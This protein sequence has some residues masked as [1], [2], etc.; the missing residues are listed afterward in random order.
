[1]PGEQPLRVPP[2]TMTGDMQPCRAASGT[3]GPAQPPSEV[4]APADRTTKATGSGAQATHPTETQVRQAGKVG[5]KAPLPGAQSLSTPRKGSSPQAPAGK[6][7]VQARV[8][9][10]GQAD[11]SPQ[12]LCSLSITSSRPKTALA[13]KTPE[14]PQR[15]TPRPPEAGTGALLRQGHPRAEASPAPEELN[16]RKCFQETP[17]SFTSTNYTSPSATPGPPPLRAPQSS[18]A[19]PCRAAPYVE[20]QASGAD[21][22][23]PLAENSFPGA[24]FGVPQAESEPFPKGGSPR[25]VSFQHPFPEL[26]GAG[27]KPFP[28]DAAGPKYSERALVFAF[29]QPRGAW[30]EEPVGTGPAYPLPAQ[31]APPPL[32]CYPGRPG[33]LDPHSDLSS[34][35]PPPGAAHL[36]P[37]PFSENAATFRDTLHESMTNVL[38]ERPPSAHDGLGS[39]REPPNSLPQRHFP[40]QV[41]GSPGASG[42][43]SSPRPLDTDLAVSGPPAAM[44]PPLWDPASATYSTPPLGPPATARSVFFEAQPSPGRRLSL[45]QSP[46]L[47]WP[48]VLPATGPSPHRMEL[49]N[50]LPFPPGTPEWQGGS[51]GALGA[52]GK[53]PGPGEK[54]VVL[55]TSPGQQGSSSPGLFTCNGLKDPGAQPLLFAVAQPQVSP[56]GTPG[57][58]PPRVVG[59]SP[60]ESPLP[61]PATHTASSSTCSSL[62]P[63]SSS[64]ANTSSEES[65][66][67]GPLTPSAFFHPPP[68]PQET[69]S[70]FP[71]PEPSH[72]LPIHYQPEPVK[73]FP[74]PTEGLGAEGAFKCL[75]ETP[76]PSSVLEV[77]SRG[78]ESFPQEPPPYSAHHFPLS[79]ASLDQ[80]DVL[81]TC[82][83][84]DRNYSSLAAFLGHRQFCGLLLARAKDGH[85]QPPALPMPPA[86]PSAQA[87]PKA[88]ASRNPSPLSHTR[89]APFLLGGDIRPD[90]KDDPLRT[91]FLPS[92]ATAPFPLP[93]ADLDLEDEA[94]LD[95]L[96]TE[97]LNG[98]GYQ[99]D[100][101]EIDSSFIDVFTDEEP[102]GPRGSTTGE[103]PKTRV[104]AMPESQ[105]KPSLQ[106]VDTPLEPQHLHPEDEDYPAGRPKTRSLGPAPTE[107]DGV[108]LVSQQRR[109]KRFKLFQKE[110]DKADTSRRPG[111]GT[112]AAR[113]RPRRTGDRAEPPPPHPRDLRT[114]APKSHADPGGRALLVETRSP[115]RLRLS[116][117]GKEAW[118]RRARGGT[119]SK[120]LIHR[121]VQQKNRAREPQA[122]QGPA[123]PSSPRGTA[124]AFPQECDS[125][126]EEED[127][128]RLR[129]PRVRG[130]LRPSGQRWHRGEKRKEGD[131]T[132]GPREDGQQRKPRKVV[133]QGA[134]RDRVSLDPEEPD[135]P[136]PGLSHSPEDGVDPE[137]RGPQRLLQVLTGAETPE[138]NPPP[139]GFPQDA[140]KPDISEELPPDTTELLRE[141]SAD[142][143]E[144]GSPC[145]PTPVHPQP[146]GEGPPASPQGE[147]PVHV[148][149]AANTAHP[150]TTALVLK[151][152]GLRCG[153][154]LPHGGPTGAP[155]ARKEP[156][157]HSSPP[158]ELLLGLKVLTGCFHEAPCPQPSAPDSLPA[159]R[160]RLHQDGVDTSSGEPAPPRNP[161]YTVVTGLGK[162]ELPLALEPTPLFS[163]LPVGSF[164]PPVY[165]SLSGNGD[166]HVP[167]ACATPPLRKPQLDPPYPSFLPEK[168]WSLLEEE[169]PMPPGHLGPF[170]GL[171]GEKAFSQK[172]PS[173]G[174]VA[175]SLPALSGKVAKCS[176]AFTGG[177]SEEELEIKR[178]VTELESQLLSKGAQEAP[179]E[180]SRVQTAGSV[181]RGTASPAPVLQ[182][183]SPCRDALSAAN[184]TGP[185]ELSP[186][187]EGEETAVAAAGGTLGSPEEEWP[188]FHPEAALPPSTH[189][190]GASL[191]FHP[192]RKARVSKT[193]LLRAEGDIGAPLEVCLL[194][195]GE[196]LTPPSDVG[197]L[198]KCSP[199]REPSPPKSNRTTRTQHSQ[200]PP[201]LLPCTQGGGPSPGSCKAHVPCPGPPEL[202]AFGSPVAH[203]TPSLAIRGA[204]VLPLGAT[205]PS[206]ASH[207]S[208]PK[209]HSVTSTGG[210]EGAR[211]LRPVAGGPGPERN[212]HFV[213]AGAST[214]PAC[215]PDPS[216]SRKPPAPATSPLHQLQLLVARAAEREDGTQSLQAPPAANTQSPQHGGPSDLGG[217]S[218]SRGKMACSPAQSFPGAVQ[219]TA[220]PATA[221]CQLGPEGDGYLGSQG[222][223]KKP[224]NQ[225]EASSLQPGDQGRPR[226]PDDL[227]TASANA[228]TTP[229]W[230]V[231]AADQLRGQRQGSREAVGLWNKTRATPSST[232]SEAD[233]SGLA[234]AAAHTRNGPED[235]TPEEAAG[236]GLKEHLPFA[237]ES[238]APPIRALASCSSLPTSAATLGPCSLQPLP[239]E[240]PPAAPSGELR[241][242]PPES[243]SCGDPTSP[244]LLPAHSPAWAPPQRADCTPDPTEAG[245]PLA[246]PPS[247]R[248]S[249]CGPKESQTCHPLLGD[250]SPLEDPPKGQP[251]SVHVLSPTHEG[252]HPGGR[253]SGAPESSRKERARQ[254]PACAT[255]PRPARTICTVATIKASALP[256]TPTTG[257]LGADRGPRAEWPDPHCRGASA[258]T[259][260]KGPS[261][262]PPGNREGQG[263]TAVPADPSTLGTAGPDLHTCWEDEAEASCQGQEGLETPGA[264]HPGIAKASRAGASGLTVTCP[265]PEFFP[266]RAT[267][268]SSTASNSRPNSPQNV[269]NLLRQRPQGDPL[270]P[271]DPRQTP[272]R[273]R[274]KP[275]F[276]ENGHWR[277]R[278]PS[279]RPVT[280]EVCLA[281]FRSGPGLS[282]HR[283]RKHG[284]HRDAASQPS[285]QATPAPKPGK[286]TAQTCHPPG[287]KSRRAPGKEKTRHSLEGPSLAAGPPPVRGTEDALG[288][289]MSERLR[290]GLSVL[291]GPGCPPGWEPHPPGLVK[292]GVDVRPAEP[293]KRD[294]LE[295]NEPRP[296]WAEK[297][298]GQRRG[299]PPADFPSKSE[300]KVNK[301]VRKPRARRFREESGP[302]V[303]PDGVSDR[304]NWNPSPTTASCPA[305]PSHHL[306]PEAERETQATQPPPL[307][308]DPEET[309][310]KKPPGDRVV[311]EAP[312]GEEPGGRKAALARGCRGPRETRTSGVCKEPPGA[313][314]GKPAGDGRVAE[315][316]SGRGAWDGREPPCGPPG[317]PGACGSEAGGGSRPQVPRHGPGDGVQEQQSA[318]PGAPSPDLGD[319]L[320]L[321]DD[322]ASFSQ[323]FPPGDRL[324]RKKNPRVYGKRCKK[325]TSPLRPEPSG[326]AGDS[327]ALSPAR[328]PT[329]LSDSGSPC[330]SHEDP[331]GGVAAG[332]PE[333]FLLEGFLS[334]KVPGIDPWAPS[335]SLLALEPDLEAD[336]RHTEDHPS[337]NIP[338][339]HMVPPAWRGLELQAPADNATS[340]LG[341][342]SPEPPDLEQEL[343]DCGV[344]GSA[345]GL[346]T[347]GAK[348]EVQALC[349][350]EG[351]SSVSCL[352]FTAMAGSQGPRSRT[353]EAARARKAP[354]RG[355]LAKAR[356]ASYKCRV[357]FQS[358]RGLGELD[359]HRLAHSPSP[360]PTCYMCVERRFGSR[361]LLREHL[362]EKH[363]QSKVGPWACGMCLRE[364]ADV[365]MYNE[366]LREHAVRFARKGQTRRTL[367]DLPGG[368]EGDGAVMHFLSGVVG[369]ASKPHRG[370][371]S[372]GKAGRGPADTLGQDSGAGKEFPRER[373][374]PKARSNSSDPDPDPDPDGASAQGSPSACA[375]PAPPGGSSPEAR[376]SG[377]PLLPAAPVHQDCKDPARDCHHCGK[378]FPKPFKLQRHLAV[379]SPQR[380]YLC[381][382]CP[383]VYPEHRE[384]RAHLGGEHGLRGELELQH[385]PLYACELCANVT[386]ISRRSF[387]CSSCNYTF[388]KKEQFDRHMDKHRRRGQQPFTFRGVRRPRALG[389]KAPAHEGSLP[390]K[391]RRVAPPSSPPRSSVDR[392][393]SRSS[394]PTLS[395]GSLP[396]LLQP[397]R[398]AAPS[399]MEGQPRTPERPIDPVGHPVRGSDLS[400]DLQELLPPSLSPFP[401]AS[402]DGKDGHKL[403]QALES[404]GD[405]ASPGSPEPLLQEAA[406]SEGSLPQPG[407]RG[408]DVGE[409]RAAGPF[410]GKRRTPSAPGKCAPNHRPE[411]SSLLWKEKQVSTCHVAPSGAT[412]GPSHKGSATKPGGCRS[413]SKDRSASS[414]PSKAPRFPAQPKK[415][416]ASPTHGE[417]ARGTEDRP[418]PTTLKAKPGPSSQGAGGPQQG[419]KTAGGSQPQPASGQLQSETATTPAKPSCPGQGPAPDKPTPRAPT[420][421]YPKG[422]REAGE[423]GPRGSL[424]PREGR[425]SSEKKRKGRAPGPTRG[426]GVGSLGRGPSVPDR[427]YRAPRKQATPSR[428]LPAKPRPCS[429]NST[430]P[431]QPSELRKGEP[432]HTHGDTRRV[433][434]GLGKAV[435]QGRPLHR[436][437]R[438]GGAVHGTEP[439]HP[440]ACRTAESQSHLLS[441]LFGQRLTSFKI[442]LKKDPPE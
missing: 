113:L 130:Q 42:V 138:E 116:P 262:E 365:W 190:N 289:E 67:P 281:S 177:L 437:P 10:A 3:G 117:G 104:G 220:D 369:Q 264:T 267:S 223:A 35:L 390:S 314:R 282:R 315:S 131:L 388:A 401:A 44:L 391:R 39:P 421:G 134:A 65:Q 167:P 46:P 230:L 58:P 97:A 94:K 434:E 127:G 158:G 23:P 229:A 258:H 186:H 47:P 169:S 119:W 296:K 328:L 408:Q 195:P 92:L 106:A 253:M 183:A 402:P 251:S 394:S 393:L 410:S 101:P 355:R 241:G 425:D 416:A 43:G 334:S 308:T 379:H 110:L 389:Q 225:V 205:P 271:Q 191:S 238:P 15:E 382:Q 103:P 199:N 420:K 244:Q 431:P 126:S 143:C 77:G 243:P 400:S 354:G 164:D 118:R 288:S 312:P 362:Q 335:P 120:E 95:S 155:A 99:S 29:H 360:P 306:S 50:Q 66:L 96:I 216:P 364:V 52:A 442:P 16:F 71:S 114:Q 109:G 304:S 294:Q 254:F 139:L 411:A 141:A 204:G 323:L 124:G 161:P 405:E 436:P 419:T 25:V 227:A 272:H 333:S 325:P 28:E 200:A 38:P 426:E 396:A 60:S 358:F 316:G 228:E 157:P 100:N 237:G 172:C 142:T 4:G 266:G 297:G 11:S 407:A 178:L 12:Q 356:R 375:T 330:L 203:L 278:A 219:L 111:Q 342:V 429:Q 269:R 86:V 292:P 317:A 132:P 61:S 274:K 348:L 326:Q 32:P 298:R 340:P 231:G 357:C 232:S 398:E 208:A 13:E 9:R 370:K 163:G 147:P 74:F 252:D 257:G 87:A 108:C 129:G 56:R 180:Q 105:A 309:S 115:K 374:R 366:H 291:G 373:P 418:K 162:A 102:S 212:E 363:V 20:F 173:E 36:A 413:S 170:P 344:P 385:T 7:L 246:V 73:A 422:P 279:G 261:S 441:Q 18:G 392:P 197:S 349:L 424:G 84:C 351:L 85:Q 301:K 70:P 386:H 57:L 211:L 259:R 427:P 245:A 305:P 53:T 189:G 415:A 395:E 214:S 247:L 439:T 368:W 397:C 93:A 81:L 430:V 277:D 160:A 78:L 414:T 372:V 91:S 285:P 233:P 37:S 175:S 181:H 352:G 48:Q 438:M 376:S 263:V 283:A 302:Q 338:E 174:T 76:F 387:V 144:G 201:L 150:E 435:P 151:P 6:N 21:A 250:C 24:S 51:Q 256:G 49:L 331:W 168:G 2:P 327:A 286:P 300:G 22:W 30:P 26:H 82:R 346:E 310:A 339:L 284:L 19:S 409:K 213:P 270:S 320:S 423:Q 159:S 280:C 122:P 399:T 154:A 380:V 83:Q 80:L 361:E 182:A 218:V 273:F 428:V 209:G 1:M 337:E 55:R 378:R 318:I 112:R 332:L 184:V 303:P 322:E 27:P 8:R 406:P 221:G 276:T 235:Q 121:I 341:D 72:T 5:P 202:E 135:G 224:E 249:P 63:L 75:E 98:L 165:S 17:S 187:P 145:P 54:L 311:E 384:L 295:R 64:P 307:A 336:P 171:S 215:M 196:P 313:A 128:P 125:E 350:P 381:P 33:G 41:S 371:R 166:T 367:G 79:S 383:R 107:A 275:A 198:A 403:D 299:R 40:R 176:S 248:T 192:V 179:G 188:S 240:D 193:G 34:A 319:P 287:K 440:R 242:P 236:P 432:S 347:L 148:A 146:R 68:H 206:G 353:V 290:K 324:T 59:A 137:E 321:F 31:P 345:V 69:G 417:L 343:Y 433:K 260:P 88:P 140:R 45:P 14:N 185:G 207:S 90:G 194:D 136:G 234:L 226:G 265:S 133:R 153:P 123:T 152:P 412:G 293:R 62:S 255:P 377:E 359:L 404:S 149:D 210:S 156:Q 239:R 222:Q 217:D 89:T 268:L 329:D